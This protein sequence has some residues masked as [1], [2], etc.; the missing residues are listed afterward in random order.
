M[1]KKNITKVKQLTDNV[2]ALAYM[3]QECNSWD[4]SLEGYRLFEFDDDFFDAYFTGDPQ[5]A[6]R[7]VFFGNIENW[8]DEYIRFNGYGNLESVS[9]WKRDQELKEG[10][11]EIIDRFLELAEEDKVDGEYL[12]S[13]Y[14]ND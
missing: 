10:A 3:V 5:E 2:E 13:E 6:A 4:D 1:T 8:M 11:S 14:C 12:I 7:A 9:D